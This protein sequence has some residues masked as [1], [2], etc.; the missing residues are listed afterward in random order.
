MPVTV[1]LSQE[2]Y[3]RLGER[4]ANELVDWFN[5]MDTAYRSELRELNQVNFA[6]FEATLE[7]RLAEFDAKA[8][9]RF[10]NFEARAEKRFLNFEARSDARI[11][12]RFEEVDR[13]FAAID[14]RLAE[15]DQRFVILEERFEKLLERSVHTQV[16]WMIGLWVTLAAGMLFLR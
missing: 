10:V 6:R 4:A 15:I 12:A 3:Q 14:Q 13:R 1:K 7:Q 5:L 9:K 16:K 2:F 11:A 8:E